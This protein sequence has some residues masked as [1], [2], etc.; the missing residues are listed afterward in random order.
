MK[1][2]IEIKGYSGENAFKL[3][4]LRLKQ[5]ASLWYVN[6]KKTKA[7]EGKS[8][9]QTWVKLKK[10]IDKKF[11]PATYKQELYLRITSLQQGSMKVKEYIGE[12]EQ[13]QI[14]CGLREE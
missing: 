14:S 9:I 5:Y 1:R 10:H 6:M 4:I 3:A 13:F 7:V 11:L 8:K 12:F 2:I